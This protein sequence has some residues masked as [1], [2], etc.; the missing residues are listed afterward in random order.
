MLSNIKRFAAAVTVMAAAF[1]LFSCSD[2]LAQF[3][4]A[5]S[6][7]PATAEVVTTLVSEQGTLT[8][9]YT[10]TYTDN[11]ITVDYVRKTLAEING[12]TTAD[13]LVITDKGTLTVGLDG[14]PS[15]EIGGL[16]LSVLTRKITLN[17][18]YFTPTING[19]VLTFTVDKEH[20]FTV[21]GVAL[22][23]PVTVSIVTADGVLKA[24]N[25]EYVTVSGKANLAATFYDTVA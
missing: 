14:T 10:A 23:Y 1:S 21:F 15:Q 7:P 19:G 16:V 6:A 25:M 8:G 20:T 22:E 2:G 13:G 17:S 9:E 11:G 24:I 4:G 3:K 18:R 5:L 12:D